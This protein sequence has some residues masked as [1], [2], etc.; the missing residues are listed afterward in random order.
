MSLSFVVA[1]NGKFHSLSLASALDQRGQLARLFTVYYSQQNRWVA[2]LVRREDRES[3]TLSRVRT[4][5]RTELPLRIGSRLPVVDRYADYL[6]ATWL[7]AWV[8]RNLVHETADVFIG[9]SNSSLASLEVAKARGMRTLVTRGSAHISYQKEILAIEYAR[10]GLRLVPPYGIEE[11]ELAEYQAADYIRIPSTYVRQTF[12]ERGVPESKLIHVP[13]AA[14]LNYFRP[15][16]RE[17]SATFR[18]L[19]LNA[20]TIQKGFYY[21][22]ELIAETKRRAIKPIEFWFIGDVE[23]FVRPALDDLLARHDN[24]RSLGRVNHYQ[25]AR[26]IS[27]C[28]VAVFPTIQEGFANTVP[29]TMACGVP[30][31]ATVNSGAGDVVND[32]DEG[33]IVPIMDSDALVE[34]VAWCFEH[35]QQCREMGRA[36]AARSQRR[37]WDDVVTELVE[38][39]SEPVPQYLSAAVG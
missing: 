26:H 20:T 33:F 9:W 4:N 1:S 36:A 29:Q 38:T 24:V 10:R 32:G 19:L 12:V 14:D 8:A 17:S 28:D 16:A 39:L 18:V 37:T 6:K 23:P 7:D 2:R 35:A 34:K 25:L 27:Q 3:I 5:V 30:V 15:Q 22:A 31:I 21:A 13:Y 11:R